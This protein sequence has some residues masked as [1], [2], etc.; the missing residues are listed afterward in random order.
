MLVKKDKQYLWKNGQ[1][2]YNPDK[3]PNSVDLEDTII[4]TMG[5]YLVEG[6][7]AKETRKRIGRKPFLLEAEPIEAVDLN[8]P[9]DFELADFIAAGRREKERAFLCNLKQRLSSAM[10]SD[11]LDN[12]GFNNQDYARLANSLPTRETSAWYCS[13]FLVFLIFL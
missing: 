12:I 8:F 3:I 4:E 5:L 10:L 2:L 11:I 6:D 13:I 7:V 9:A 1:P